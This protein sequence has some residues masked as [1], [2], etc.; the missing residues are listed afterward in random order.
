MKAFCLNK[1]VCTLCSLFGLLQISVRILTSCFGCNI[2]LLNFVR[3]CVR[4]RV[5]DTNN[6]ACAAAAT[7]IPHPYNV[8]HF[9]FVLK[10]YSF[11]DESFSRSPCSSMIKH[12]SSGADLA[13]KCILHIA[14]YASIHSNLIWIVSNRYLYGHVLFF[15][16]SHLHQ[17]ADETCTHIPYT[18]QS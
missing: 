4:V 18:M 12:E 2:F 5:R 13:L 11:I 3:A 1:T 16:L 6:N 17:E 14:Q 7:H 15:S 8:D 10:I 9:R